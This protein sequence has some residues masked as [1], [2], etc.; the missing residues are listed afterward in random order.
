MAR[1]DGSTLVVAARFL[2]P[3]KAQCDLCPVGALATISMVVI[4]IPSS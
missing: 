1:Q 3:I 4:F 2:P